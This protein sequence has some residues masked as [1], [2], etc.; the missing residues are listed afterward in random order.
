MRYHWNTLY[1]YTFEYFATTI[2][3]MQ[4]Q[5]SLSN[6]L[7]EMRKFIYEWKLCVNRK[8]VGR[9]PWAARFQFPKQMAELVGIVRFVW[10]IFKH[11]FI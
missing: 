11:L 2:F 1:C 6:D 8:K 3:Q 7:L 10:E 4:T 5:L 9:L